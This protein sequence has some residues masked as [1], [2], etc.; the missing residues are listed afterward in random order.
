MNTGTIATFSYSNLQGWCWIRTGVIKKGETTSDCN[1]P[2]ISRNNLFLPFPSSLTLPE[3][4][5]GSGLGRGWEWEGEREG[6]LSAKFTSA[7]IILIPH[8]LSEK[9]GGRE[10]VGDSAVGNLS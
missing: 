8:S 5:S 1:S 4:R 9:E 10:S 7:A 3:T 6:Y 2:S